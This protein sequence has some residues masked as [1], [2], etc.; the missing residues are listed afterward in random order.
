MNYR[1]NS[2]E[3]SG[4][5]PETREARKSAF[6]SYLNCDFPQIP[7]VGSPAFSQKCGPS[8]SVLN[9]F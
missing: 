8:E 4:C 9:D 5:S 3:D 2:F 7:E 6:E 1:S